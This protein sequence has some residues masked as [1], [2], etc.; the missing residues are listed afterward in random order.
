M[1]SVFQPFGIDHWFVLM[2]TTVTAISILASSKNIRAA[3]NDLNFRR[4]YALGLVVIGIISWAYSYLLIDGLM[5]LPLQLCDLALFLTA[6]ALVKRNNLVSELAFFWGF[7]GST[8]ALLT[9]DLTNGFPN[10]L[11]FSFFLS[12]AGVILGAIY[13]MVRGRISLSFGSVNRVFFMTNVYAAVIGVVN[14]RL[15]TNFGYLA[16]KPDHSSLLDYLGPWPVYIFWTELIALGLYFFCYAFG[17]WIDVLAGQN[18]TGD[19]KI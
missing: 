11:W 4:G 1:K 2:L 16:S 12:H 7:S 14:W 8:Q 15:G 19:I 6:L 17:R 9:P 3:K 10:F 5:H 18:K 13:L